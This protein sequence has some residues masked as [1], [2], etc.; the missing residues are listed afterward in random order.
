MPPEKNHCW[1]S[2]TISLRHS[3]AYIFHRIH[4]TVVRRIFTNERFVYIVRRGSMFLVCM[5]LLLIFL[6]LSFIS[7]PLHRIQRGN[8]WS[9]FYQHGLIVIP[10]WVSN[11]THYKVCDEITNLIPSSNCCII[12]AWE[13]LKL[14]HVCKRGRRCIMYGSMGNTCLKK[15]STPQPVFVSISSGCITHVS[16]WNEQRRVEHF[17]QLF[18]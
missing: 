6:W 10:A 4:A 16:S 12:E 17:H 15:T 8:V 14:N 18:K 1:D 13:S 7:S 3:E 5:G 2:S 9:P 11:Y